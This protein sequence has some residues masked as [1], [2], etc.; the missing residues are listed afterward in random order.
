MT[1]FE[2]TFGW[3]LRLFNLL[4]IV[5]SIGWPL[6]SLATLFSLRGRP[7]TETTQVV[8]VLLIIAVP[9]LGALAYWIVRPGAKRE[10]TA[11]GA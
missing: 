5:A 7:L 2:M 4:L 1:G 9:Y 6:L 11:A 10:G 8:W 3:L